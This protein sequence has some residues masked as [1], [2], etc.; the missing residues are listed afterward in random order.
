[1]QKNLEKLQFILNISLNNDKQ[2]TKIS[3]S[4]N[5]NKIDVIK[6]LEKAK[7]I[8]QDISNSNNALKLLKKGDPENQITHS[9]KKMHEEL[10]SKQIQFA[11][12]CKQAIDV[13]N[14]PP[15]II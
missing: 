2:N 15:S 6:K 12:M 7:Q 10:R 5:K 9:A 8:L 1:M 14:T 3:T 11:E 4:Y 13:K